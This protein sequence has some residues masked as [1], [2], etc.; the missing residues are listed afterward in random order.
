M[1]HQKAIAK[2][3]VRANKNDSTNVGENQPNQKKMQNN[4]KILTKL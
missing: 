2:T 3:T 4:A 1:Q